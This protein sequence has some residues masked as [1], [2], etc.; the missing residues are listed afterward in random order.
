M[1][2]QSFLQDQRIL[3][4]MRVSTVDGRPEDYKEITQRR[5]RKADEYCNNWKVSQDVRCR[6][7]Q[8]YHQFG[9]N[10][11]RHSVG[12]RRWHWW[13]WLR[14]SWS[15]FWQGNNVFASPIRNPHVWLRR[16]VPRIEPF[17]CSCRDSRLHTCKQQYRRVYVISLKWMIKTF[18][19]GQ[20]N[21]WN[22]FGIPN[23]D[24]WYLSWSSS[25]TTY[26]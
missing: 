7:H 20:H 4:V 13:Q 18:I 1:Q 12:V 6:H 15:R 2:K 10:D 8:F 14:Q 25:L 23:L 21:F 24:T 17:D 26:L 22:F 5:K 3:L 16:L 11:Q 9:D 19:R